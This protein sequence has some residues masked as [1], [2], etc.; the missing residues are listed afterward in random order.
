MRVLCSHGK[1]IY[2]CMKNDKYLKGIFL[3][4]VVS[5]KLIINSLTRDLKQ[6]LGFENFCSPFCKHGM[7]KVPKVVIL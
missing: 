2:K 1:H 5:D 6:S 4:V 3:V 7:P